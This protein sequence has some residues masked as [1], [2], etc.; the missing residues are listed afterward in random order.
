MTEFVSEIKTIPH[1]N[2]DVY[3][4][5]SDLSYLE[6]ARDRMPEDAI[7]DLTF[8][9]DSCS[10]TA[11]PI[12]KIKFKVVEREP[13][14]TV[15]FVSEQLPFDVTMWIQL[16]PS[17]ESETKMKL[18]IK[19]EL[20]PFIKPMVSKPLQSG[21]EKVADRLSKLPYSDILKKEE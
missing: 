17:G 18:T 3:T 1:T 5:L 16:L 20:N 13:Q 9:E 6:Q 8:E 21:I 12:G 4:V 10:I 14:K 11:D 19:A 7:K 2:A 15:K